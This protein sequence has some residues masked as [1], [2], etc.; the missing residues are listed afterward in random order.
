MLAHSTPISPNLYDND[1]HLWLLQTR[2]KLE[3]RDFNALDL[4][5]LIEEITDLARRDKRAIKNL[6]KQLVEHLLKLKYWDREKSRNQGHWQRE[7]LNFRQQIQDYLNESPSLKPYLNEI[8]P[9]CYRDGRQLAANISQLPLNTFPE[10]PITD[11]DTL[12]N[13]DWLP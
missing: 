12:L 3:T 4:E 11:L 10:D 7:I 2:Q 1:Y 5:N 8:Y 9:S 13:P 6:L